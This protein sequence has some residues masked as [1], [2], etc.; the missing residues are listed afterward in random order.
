MTCS[1]RE[2]PR[3]SDTHDDEI[4]RQISREVQNSICNCSRFYDH[5]WPV[6]QFGFGR[7]HVAQAILVL[8]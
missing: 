4:S 6:M 2:G 8:A 7:D 1:L 3:S 5:L